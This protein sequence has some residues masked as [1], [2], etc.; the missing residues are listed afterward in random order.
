MAD[1]FS[2]RDNMENDASEVKD[3]LKTLTK[4]LTDKIKEK[5]EDEIGNRIAKH[6]ADH[7][8][9][10]AAQS[11]AQ[12]AGTAS[13]AGAAGADAASGAGASGV[14]ASAAGAGTGGAAA[15]ASAEAGAAGGT[16][17]STTA[18]GTALSATAGGTAAGATGGAVAEGAAAGAA[19][20]PVGI[21]VGVIIGAAIALASA[22]KKETDISLDEDDPDGPKI[23]AIILM[24]AIILLG[25]TTLCGTLISKGVAS[26]VSVG[27]ETE[28]QNTVVDG[29][30]MA[31]A[32]QQY[33]TG[34]TLNEYNA[35]LPLKNAIWNYTFGSDRTGL[36]DGL[37]Q[38]LSKAIRRHC[39]NIVQQLERHTGNIGDHPYDS[40][41]SLD[42][43][44]QN[45]WP[46]DL[47]SSTHTPRIGDV[48]I[49]NST[50]YDHTYTEWNPR[51][52]DVNYAEIFSV[53]S[54]T[55]SVANGAT[56]SFDWGD[57]NYKD[58][59]EYLQKEECY[60]YMY[61]LGLKW[62]PVYRGEKEI[63]EEHDPDTDEDD[64]SYTITIEREPYEYDSPDECRGAPDSITWDDVVCDWEE[65][66][67]KVT[68]K[69]MGLRE[70]FAMA[71]NT[72]DP[73]SA[74]NLKH[75]NF[76]QHQNMYMLG[77]TERVT[78]LY[79]RDD[80]VDYS[81]E[82]HVVSDG[83]DPLGPSF[84]KPRSNRSSVYWDVNNSE[85]LIARGWQGTGRS[86]WYYIEKTYN[87]KFD[88]IEWDEDP[89]GSPPPSEFEPPEG[90]KILDM[91]EYINQGDYPDT[92]RGASG[93]TIKK[94]GCLDC[95]VAMIAMYYKRYHIPVT[96][97]SKHVDAGGSL[98]TS[99]ALAEFGLRQSGNNGSDVIGGVISEIN[100]DRPVILHIRGYW[101]SSED[102]R[103]L[104]GTS[105]GHFL[106]GMG[107]DQTGLYVWDPGRR[108]NY[109]IA[110]ED[111]GHVSDLYYRS[112]TEG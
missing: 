90:G 53:F 54:M 103:V 81:I 78:R 61:E 40:D 18:G 80:K 50:F 22:I 70:L 49:P 86:P 42:S 71:F 34:T 47:K 93:E 101:T 67:V 6:I 63:F 105:N 88:V 99:D 100:A 106:V 37:R 109:H 77:Y 39:K 55:D 7:G 79:Q 14:G 51:Y 1:E 111:W 65:Y 92:L 12:T 108:A 104:H 64:E 83:N 27:Q 5:A 56:Y 10:N 73:V 4:P 74:S 107:Y 21:V 9:K 24:I 13:A 2:I 38:T 43:F 11:T 94:S 62:V 16:A 58:F 31:L 85:W 35:S 75:V 72:T 15:G 41:R 82:G 96:E 45:K 29:Q 28:F 112:V 46:Y 17:L 95:S 60:K 98:H 52:D 8:A 69:P 3:D 91:F 25:F 33:K 48:L 44:Y 32:G 59:M 57:V 102:G 20:G 66:Y 76:D 68:V 36:T 97:V 87:D 89:G 30:N 23:N 26:T 19:G 84:K 110:Y